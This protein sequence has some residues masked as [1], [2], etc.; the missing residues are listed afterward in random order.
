M[1]R[2]LLFAVLKDAAG[3]DVLELH[4]PRPELSLPELLQLCAEACPALAKY[5]PHVRVAIDLEY[6]PNTARVR[7]DQEIA[8]LPPVSGGAI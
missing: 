3:R 5:L 8:L 1:F 2:V 6:A 7:S 4:D